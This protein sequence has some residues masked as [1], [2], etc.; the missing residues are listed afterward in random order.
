[1]WIKSDFPLS[2]RVVR[3]CRRT[4]ARC[5]FEVSYAP[6]VVRVR[7]AHNNVDD[8]PKLVKHQIHERRQKIC[9]DGGASN[10]EDR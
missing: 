2:S 8:G 4:Q 7:L 1:M 3:D 5:R 10:V 6:P 9:R